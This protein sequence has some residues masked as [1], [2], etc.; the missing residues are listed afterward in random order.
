MHPD[1]RETTS[2]DMS[3]LEALYRS[4]FPQENLIPLVRRLLDDMGNVLSL[5]AIRDGHIFGHIA[6]TNCE[7]SPSGDGIALLGSLAVAPA[8]QNQG[9]GRR[10]VHG[11]LERL[12]SMGCRQVQVL[13]DPDYYRRFGFEQD[14]HVTPPYDLPEAWH[15]AWQSVLLTRNGGRVKGRLSVLSAWQEK[16]LWLP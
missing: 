10:L 15:R 9:I 7:I 5:A 4:A 14:D 13:G 6:F 2:D 8:A 3:A 11:G 16:S 12:A 1:L